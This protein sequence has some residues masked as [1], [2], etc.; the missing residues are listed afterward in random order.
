M[1]HQL[2]CI[3]DIYSVS[4]T[5]VYSYQTSTTY[6]MHTYVILTIDART[7]RVKLAMNLLLKILSSD[8]R[9]PTAPQT[10]AQNA[11]KAV[12]GVAGTALL[13]TQTLLFG[14]SDNETAEIWFHSFSQ[15]NWSHSKLVSLSSYLDRIM[16]QTSKC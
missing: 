16:K 9:R 14:L 1:S 8:R 11:R 13:Y 2:S 6:V 3:P 4:Y 10:A 5:W 7:P 12:G 15:S